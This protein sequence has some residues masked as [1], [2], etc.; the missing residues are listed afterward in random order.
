[1]KLLRIFPKHYF[2]KHQNKNDKLKVYLNQV[3]V[4]RH[5]QKAWAKMNYQ[6][7]NYWRL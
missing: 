3:S 5:K 2:K 7:K 1:M 4:P 6:N